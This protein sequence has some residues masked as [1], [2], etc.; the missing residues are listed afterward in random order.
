MTI[1]ALAA[2][3]LATLGKALKTGATMRTRIA[4]PKDGLSSEF[5]YW[6]RR[7]QGVVIHAKYGARGHCL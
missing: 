4:S 6:R 5:R 1:W 7:F 2:L 3:L